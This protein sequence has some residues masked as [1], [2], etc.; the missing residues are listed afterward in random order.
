MLD[1]DA[2]LFDCDGTLIHTLDIWIDACQKVLADHGATVSRAEIGKR[3]GQWE[4]M[5]QGVPEA[6]FAQAVKE[7]SAIAHPQAAKAPLYDDVASVL[8]LLKTAGKKLALITA[9]DK[10]VVQKILAYHNL[11]NTFDIVVTGSDI[12]QHKPDPEG[13]NAVL[14]AFGTPKHK[15]IM[16]GDSDKD[17]GAAKNAGIDSLLFYPE[18]HKTA[19]DH[20]F[21]ASFGPKYTIAHWNELG[22]QLATPLADATM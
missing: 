7:V 8:R 16:L 14:A 20:S 13:I 21:L 3:L 9:T 5:L 19:H 2:Y 6:E 18:S 17:L 1:Y 11:E 10:S 22:N 12:S 15:A 4:L